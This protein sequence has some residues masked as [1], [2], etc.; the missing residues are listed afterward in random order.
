MFMFRGDAPRKE[1]AAV[2]PPVERLVSHP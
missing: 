1:M 2:L